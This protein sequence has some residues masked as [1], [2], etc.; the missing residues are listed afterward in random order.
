MEG[1]GLDEVTGSRTGRGQPFRSL[2]SLAL[3]TVAA[4]A[5]LAARADTDGGQTLQDHAAPLLAACRLPAKAAGP[6]EGICPLFVSRLAAAFPGREVRAAGDPAGAA[7]VLEVLA[8]TP[9][10]LEARIVAAGAAPGP[11]LGTARADA[12]LD[13]AAMAPVLDA[14]IAGAAMPP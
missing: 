12:P 6:V 4:C 9:G 2:R 3:A 8:L 13:E 14:L 1:R 11:A 5:A 7:L 10:R